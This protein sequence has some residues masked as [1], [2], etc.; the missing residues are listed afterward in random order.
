[1]Q[2]AVEQIEQRTEIGI[3]YIINV[4]CVTYIT[5]ITTIT[6]VI[7]FIKAVHTRL[8]RRWASLGEAMRVVN[9][10]SHRFPGL[11]LR[12]ALRGHFTLLPS[13]RR[14]Q[15]CA[16]LPAPASRLRWQYCWLAKR[17]RAANRTNRRAS[18]T[19]NK[20]RHRPTWLA[21]SS[22]TA[23]VALMLPI[24][25]VLL[26]LIVLLILPVTLDYSNC[27]TGITSITD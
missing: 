13:L 5:I 14:N 16:T 3:T 6:Y 11:L 8:L 10:A 9:P 18:A 17:N 27:M 12:Q 7:N 19:G 24:L 4:I 26:V 21:G 23:R 20:R 15:A 25:T 2:L 22:A 1:M